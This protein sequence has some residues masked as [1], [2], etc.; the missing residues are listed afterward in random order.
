MQ[1]EPIIFDG[2]ID[3]NIKYGNPNADEATIHEVCKM[4]NAHGFIKMLPK[5]FD[6]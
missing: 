6:V 5:V 1:Q 4:A 2:T 3:E